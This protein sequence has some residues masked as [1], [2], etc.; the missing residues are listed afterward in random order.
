MNK[1]KEICIVKPLERTR[2]KYHLYKSKIQREV[3]TSSGRLSY[4]LGDSMAHQNEQVHMIK[5]EW[6]RATSDL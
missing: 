5:S 6:V 4:F 3:S 2:K 1:N